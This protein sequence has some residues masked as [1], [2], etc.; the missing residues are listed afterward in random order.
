LG[1]D[2]IIETLIE[3]HAIPSYMSFSSP[4]TMHFLLLGYLV[5]V[6]ALASVTYRLIEQ[7]GRAFFNRLSDTLP[8]A[9]P[10]TA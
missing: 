8:T 2:K 7:P 4:W 3:R 1:S 6:V 9:D 10:R 5:V